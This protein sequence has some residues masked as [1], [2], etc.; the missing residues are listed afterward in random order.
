[1][2]LLP[3]TYNSGLCRRQEYRERFHAR[4]VVYVGITNPWWRG[5]CSRHSRRMRNPH[6]YVSSMRPCRENN[7]PSLLIL[8]LMNY[9][10][11]FGLFID[12]RMEGDTL[13]S[14]AKCRI[15]TQGLRHQIASRVN[16]HWHWTD[17]VIEDQAK[18]FTRHPIPVISEQ[19]AHS[20]P[21]PVCFRKWLWRYTCLL[22]LISMLC[23]RQAIF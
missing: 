23:H 5:K 13:S 11:L 9:L 12:F 14:S 6:F 20:T 2:G 3:D 19:S 16:A 7:R 1:M 10:T 17:W 15:R 18:T 4:A 8:F 22:L 21:L